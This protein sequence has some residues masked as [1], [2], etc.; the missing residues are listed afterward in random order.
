MGIRDALINALQESVNGLFVVF[1]MNEWY[2]DWLLTLF[3]VKHYV[4]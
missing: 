1:F 4:Y 2:R 3:N